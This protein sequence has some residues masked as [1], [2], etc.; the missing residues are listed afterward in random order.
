MAAVATLIIR[1]SVNTWQAATG[2]GLMAAAL[3]G[4]LGAAVMH[5]PG[6]NHGRVSS[7]TRHGR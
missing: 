5:I 2:L 1:G 7:K 4:L 6:E 3:A